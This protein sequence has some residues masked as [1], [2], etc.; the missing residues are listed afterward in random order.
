MVGYGKFCRCLV[1]EA[2]LVNQFGQHYTMYEP[3]VQLLCSLI[4]LFPSDKFC[5]HMV[6]YCTVQR[7]YLVGKP[8]VALWKSI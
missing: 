3:F 1:D 6:K 7:Y 2:L 4:V 8:L 5:V